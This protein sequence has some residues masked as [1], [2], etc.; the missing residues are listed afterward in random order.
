MSVRVPLRVCLVADSLGPDAGTEKLV[1]AMAGAFDPSIIEPYVCCFET[2]ERLAALPENVR[3]A[4]FPLA[5]V[6]SLSGLRQ[7]L[8][9]HSYL[10]RNGIHVVHAFMSKSALFCLLASRGAGCRAVITSRLNSG[11][12]HTKRLVRALRF[13]NRYS[14]HIWSNSVLAKDLAVSVEKVT[15]GKI[16]VV[17]PGVDLQR[18]SP[19]SANP[20]AA[21]SL[22]IPPNALVV[23]IVANFRPVK[24][25]PLFLRAAA[26]VSAAVPSAAFLLVGQGA[27]KAELQKLAAELGI[28]DRVFFSVPE[29]P[30]PD[31]LARFSVACLSSESEGLPNAI[32]EYMAVGLPVVATDVGGVSELIRSGENGFLVRE[33]TPNAFAEPVI[34]LLQNPEI[35]ARMGRLGFERARAEFDLSAAILRLQQFYLDAA[36]IRNG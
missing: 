18:F 35:R 3:R 25:L 33:H 6:N 34:R 36:G 9:F 10:K 12:W 7:V 16:T 28:A 24:D 26:L 27:L 19:G 5:K 22:G 13:L 15:P 32:L 31:Y 21:A 2:D 8:R 1:A 11:Y 17:Y 29:V 14:T 23:G 4:V 20:A 30:V